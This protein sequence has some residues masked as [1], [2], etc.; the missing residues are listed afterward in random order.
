[1]SYKMNSSNDWDGPQSLLDYELELHEV[2]AYLWEDG[3]SIEE[4]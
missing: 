3:D 2:R 4:S 1:M